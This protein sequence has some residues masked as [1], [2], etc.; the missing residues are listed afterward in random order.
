MSYW[1]DWQWGNAGYYAPFRDVSL[2]PR[3]SGM[4]TPC[5]V[6]GEQYTLEDFQKDYPQFF[7]MDTNP[8]TC[9]MVPESI[10]EALLGYVNSIVD[11]CRWGN[12]WYVGVGLAMAHLTQMYI[13]GTANPGSS[14]EALMAQQLTGYVTNKQVGDL[15]I[16]YDLSF[17][18]DKLK[19]W[20]TWTL[21]TYGAQFASMARIFYRFGS[22][23]W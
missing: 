16:S 9:Q 11:K 14:K 8:P 5:C 20:G 17:L 7:G 1:Y 10:L 21:T 3:A 4:K 12:A 18:T 23:V 2:I 13:M 19:D 6:A 22:Y 15:S